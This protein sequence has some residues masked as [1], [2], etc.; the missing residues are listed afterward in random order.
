MVRKNYRNILAVTAA[1][2]VLGGAV[3]F[4]G[5][6]KE[7]DTTCTQKQT[8]AAAVQ[9]VGPNG[10]AYLRQFNLAFEGG[11]AVIGLYDEEAVREFAERQPLSIPLQRLPD[12]IIITPALPDTVFG[13]TDGTAITLAVGDIIMNTDTKEIALYCQDE[14][15]VSHGILLGHVIS[16]LEVL[17]QK[18]GTFEGFAT[19]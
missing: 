8:T 14:G 17:S 10:Q 7:A 9:P 6:A 19:T 11:T 3:A 13:R 16:G 15:S 1:V 4:T 12:R 2:L 18:D 5:C